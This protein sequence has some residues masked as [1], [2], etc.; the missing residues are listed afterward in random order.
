MRIKVMKFGGT[1][2]ASPESRIASALRVVSAKEQGFRP[3]VVVS[4]I[5]RKGAPYATDTLI[6][7]LREID[8]DVEPDARELD[9]LL[10]CGEILSAV[11]FAH[12]LKTL[13]HPAQ[14]FR[15]GQ[16]G[17]RTDGVYGN[18]RIVG[19]NPVSL[20]RS[21]E[22]GNIP[23]VCGFQ[24]VYVAGDG[25]PG[26]ELTT[27]GRGGSDTTGA[28]IGAAMKAEA[29]EIFTDV[30][31]IKTAD[32][33][34]VKSAPTLRKVTYDEV[35][36]IAHLGAKVVHPRAAEVAMHYD[37][38]L[39]VKN[40]FSDDEGTEIVKREHFPGRR[41]TGVTH[42]GKLVYLQ[43]DLSGANDEDRVTLES[44]IYETMARYGVNLFMLDMSPS[45]TGFAVPRSQYAV[46]EDVLD[47]LVIPMVCEDRR[48]YLFQI[49]QQPSREVETQAALLEALG[50]VRR[51][52]AQLTEGCTMVSLVGHEYM[53]QP[54]LFLNVLSTLYENQIAVLQTSDSDFSLSVLVPE[55]DTLRAVRLLHERFSLAEVR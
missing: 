20:F 13:G 42:T 44:R 31:G 47:G 54:G 10:A 37:I 9:L 23:V 32:P 36:E 1:S 28:A 45:S 21:V 17:I 15:G 53:Q 38:P 26:G 7:M 4:A 34:A 52:S 41:V 3:V 51:I 12:T 5:G 8:P 16:A 2:V 25:A 49:G 24:G 33:D 40:T 14:A 30:D 19:I 11:I 43:F 18:A 27:L 39:W 35:A 50:D 48:V 6:N 22:Q 55:S 29:V 46:V